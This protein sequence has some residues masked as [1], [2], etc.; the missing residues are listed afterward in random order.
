MKG[1]SSRFILFLF[2]ADILLTELA[3]FLAEVTRRVIPFGGESIGMS[4]L[5]T[6]ILVAVALFWAFFLRLFGAYDPRRLASFVDEGRAVLLATMAGMLGMAAFFYLFNID[7]RSRMLFGYFF[8][9]DLA[10]L[11]N[12]RL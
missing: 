8:A 10:L 4:F 11:L 6:H 3:L 7:F 9:I 12:Y 2:L 1:F 5:D